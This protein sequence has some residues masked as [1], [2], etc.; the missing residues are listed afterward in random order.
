MCVI[1]TKEC[2]TELGSVCYRDKRMCDRAWE[3]ECVC[4]CVL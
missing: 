1:E 2:V 4:V 3:C